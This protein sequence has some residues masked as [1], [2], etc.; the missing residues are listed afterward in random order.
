[1][2]PYHRRRRRVLL[3]AFAVSAIAVA[4]SDGDRAGNPLAPAPATVAASHA[5]LDPTQRL[6]QGL[7][8]ALRD[9]AV[10]T[11]V[12]D[13]ISSSPYVEW[14][15]PLRRLLTRSGSARE[16]LL[17]PARLTGEW[18]GLGAALPELELY[19]PFHSQRLEWSGGSDVQVAAPAG[20]HDYWLFATDGSASLVPSSYI[21]SRPTL[22]LA[23]SEI[24]FDDTESALRGGART[25]GAARAL[26]PGG[27]DL[28]YGPPM[29]QMCYGEHC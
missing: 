25:G 20:N 22:L 26:R 7:A 9:S 4:C 23:R 8:T 27:F 12:A 14:R 17:A 24:D 13:E 28:G 19:F 3:G 21:P 15:V 18:P 11:W 10:R 2:E 29:R 6:A 16:M 5:N 1:M